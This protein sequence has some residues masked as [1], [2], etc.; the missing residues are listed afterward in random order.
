MKFTRI[1]LENWR[2][3]KSVDQELRDRVFVIGPNAA[4]KT[5]LLD[6]FQFL[7]DICEPIGGGFQQAVAAR[8]GMTHLRSLMARENPDVSIEVWIDGGPGKTW[9]YKLAFGQKPKGEPL[10]ALRAEEL[11]GPGGVAMTPR[12]E[13]SE[14]DDPEQLQQTLL[15]NKSRNQQFRPLISFFNSI[16]YCHVVPS[17]IRLPRPTEKGHRDSF[18]SDFLGMVAGTPPQERGRRLSVILRALEKVVPHISKL[19]MERDERGVP[20]LQAKYKHWRPQGSW[21]NEADLSDGTLRLIG[22]LW[23]LQEKTGP[24]LLEEPE[25][26]LHTEVVR[27]LPQIFARVGNLF[28]RQIFVST[29]SQDLLNDRGISPDEI[30]LLEATTDGTVVSSIGKTQNV[31]RLFESGV[32]LGEAA[33]PYTRPPDLEQ[34]VFSFEGRRAAR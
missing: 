18:G 33:S 14:K 29:H 6:V 4:G 34:L 24:L 10:P 11:E 31:V 16:Q 3:F 30:L 2:N 5:N 20:H 21:Q 13:R 8:L 7:K 17:L 1:K 32:P 27:L 9:R 12:P 15:E 23:A 19:T 25:H 26:S 28:D 22:F